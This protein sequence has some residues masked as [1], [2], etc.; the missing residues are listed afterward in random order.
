MAYQLVNGTGYFLINTQEYPKGIYKPNY[1]GDSIGLKYADS[2]TGI[3]LPPIPFSEWLDNTGTPYVSVAALK[4]D[5]QAFF[6]DIITSGP[7]S[8]TDN[9]V[10]RYDGTTGKLLQDSTVIIDDAG[11][12]T[13]PGK[14][15]VIGIIDPTGLVLDEQA[16]VPFTPVTGKSVLW[17]KSDSPN[18]PLFTDDTARD[19]KLSKVPDA[20]PLQDGEFARHSDVDGGFISSSIIEETDEIKVNKKVKFNKGQ[21]NTAGSIGLGDLTISEAGAA[22]IVD[23]LNRR[24]T[25][26]QNEITSLGSSPTFVPRVTAEI[27]A[28]AQTSD[29]QTQVLSSVSWFARATSDFIVNAFIFRSTTNTSGVRL[30]VRENDAVGRIVTITEEDDPW[31]DGDGFSL[32]ATGDTSI[33]GSIGD[34]INKSL[35]IPFFDGEVLHF[36]LEVA[37]GTF[38]IKGDTVEFGGQ[39]SA[40]VPFFSDKEQEFRLP[41]LV[42][43]GGFTQTLTGDVAITPGTAAVVGTGT[44]FTSELVVGES[45]QIREENFTVLSI[46]DNTNFTLSGNHVTGA[47]FGVGGGL[48][49]IVFAE[50][51]LLTVKSFDGSEHI[52]VDKEGN[53]TINKNLNVNGTTISFE[54]ETINIVDN[55]LYLNKGYSTAVAQSG[56]LVINYLPT[57]IE[58]TVSTGTFTAGIDSTSNP[59]VITVGSAIFSL[60]DIV[61]IDGTNINENDGI[62][63]V[64]SHITTTL[65]IRGIGITGTVEDFTQNQFITNASDNATITKVNVS[66]LRSGTDGK[67]ESANGSATGFA[68]QKL[69]TQA[70]SLTD[71][72]VLFAD[73]N[74]NITEDNANL[75]YD[76]ATKR[77]GIG[78]VSPNANL[79]VR[80]PGGVNVGGFPSG[81]LHVTSTLASVNSN[82]V[83]TGHNLFGGNKQ[84]WYF[85][86]TSSSNDNIA[87]I[88][89]QNAELHFHT[90]DTKY[91]T[92][93]S[94]GRFILE[95]DIQ[96]K[97]GLITSGASNDLDVTTG[98][99]GVFKFN[100]NALRSGLDTSNYL[101][102]GHGGSNGFINAV[103]TSAGIDFRFEGITK[104]TFTVAGHLHLLTDTDQKHNLKIKTANNLS[105][106]GIAWENSGGNF[107]QTIF[108]TDVGSNR[109]DLIFAIGSDAN[110]DLLTNSFRIHGS[111]ADEGK[112][113]VIG[114]F[115]ISSGSP[116]VNRVLT[117]DATGNAS[118]VL[119]SGGGWTDSG[120]N[121]ILTNINDS[122]GIG[123]SGPDS[124]L[125]VTDGGSAGTVT[126]ITNTIATFESPGA[127]YI[128]IL[129]PNANERGIFFGEPASQAAGG[130]IYNNSATL[131]GL[132]FRVNGN[133]TEMILKSDGDINLNAYPNTRDDGTPIN[134]LGTDASGNLISGPNE[135]IHIGGNFTD[136]T[137]QT[138]SVVSTKQSITFNQNRLIDNISHSTTVNPDTFTINTD[139]VYNMIIAPQLAQG[140]GAATV[141]FWIE[142]N[143][144]LIV[145]SNVQETIGANSQSLPL[146]R[147][148]ESF[149]A[150]DTIKIIWASNSLNTMLDNITSTYGG[151]NIPSIMFGITHVG[152]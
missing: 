126:A 53:M 105:D 13:I 51:N 102:V 147:W 26:A 74:G 133:S 3:V 122:V 138:I 107:S 21:E 94:G 127:G 148:K 52:I 18:N 83:I 131:D 150:T 91:L 42:D 101:E 67:W 35:G 113:E 84:L 5:I 4:A 117:S 93:E 54:S 88:N 143:G 98:T 36:T 151:P 123:E 31:N 141:E 66:V 48:N 39:P 6:F 16:T 130:I 28:P 82:A 41:I 37:S 100:S 108:R 29:A 146:L 103:G 9:A 32:L 128:S 2:K 17:A 76:S 50:N 34:P 60:G 142:K 64:L 119:P 14:L 45:I 73:S 149:V 116:A 70:T 40:F 72:S 144:T 57:A 58:T 44:L 11:N 90:N 8:S 134:I 95:Q 145:D 59:T 61:Q 20:K 137:D 86:S 136:T 80:G 96:I 15:T 139:G 33:G 121:I 97:G 106:S 69:T 140:S 87:F 114:A 63:E 27:I 77:F 43:G 92:L 10:A 81:A 12:M 115:Q 111:V 7:S 129:T 75:S 85:G 99:G 1:Q 22:L 152:S 118:W 135:V 19:F 124:K 112:L 120:A 56:G 109:S 110:I 25:F 23:R 125:H 104:S 38:G 132:Q 30:V 46:T 68:F 47:G 78:T 24:F 71:K 65:T 55:H 79:D 49:A 62:Y 89:R